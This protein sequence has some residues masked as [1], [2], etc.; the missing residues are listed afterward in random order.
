MNSPM[1]EIKEDY[2]YSPHPPRVK[3]FKVRDGGSARVPM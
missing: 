1:T 3:F 2:G